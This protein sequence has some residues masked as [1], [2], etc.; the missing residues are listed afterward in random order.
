ML[1]SG[2]FSR[3]LRFRSRRCRFGVHC[4]QRSGVGT[5]RRCINHEQTDKLRYMQCGFPGDPFRYA[6]PRLRSSASEPIRSCSDQRRNAHSSA[7]RGSFRP[8]PLSAL[9][10][11]PKQAR[12][13]H[14]TGPY[15]PDT[16]AGAFGPMGARGANG[17]PSRTDYLSAGF[18]LHDVVAIERS[19]CAC[20]PAHL[21]RNPVA[22]VRPRTWNGNPAARISNARS[23]PA[24]CRGARRGLSRR[25]SRRQAWRRWAP[26]VRTKSVENL[27]RC[28]RNAVAS[29]CPGY[30]L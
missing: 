8:R 4:E 29:C 6:R 23:A 28:G 13:G 12:N 27:G 30:A 21:E 14:G 19:G 10:L 26:K 1:N 24:L 2:C 11:V 18:V 7:A 25:F 3:L 22:P 15:A 9:L 16:R 5:T 20:M 17:V